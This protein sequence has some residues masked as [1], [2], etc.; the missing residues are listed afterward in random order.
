M[1]ED[2]H[3]NKVLTY[4]MPLGFIMLSH[5]G[6]L[7]NSHRYSGSL[8]AVSNINRVSSVCLFSPNAKCVYLQTSVYIVVGLVLVVSGDFLKNKQSWCRS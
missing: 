8:H 1:R 6:L 7:I 4:A 3:E 5:H 2:R